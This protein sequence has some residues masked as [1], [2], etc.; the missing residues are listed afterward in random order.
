MAPNVAL[1]VAV[2]I[3]FLRGCERG[4]VR[5]GERGGARGDDGAHDGENDGAHDRAHEPRGDPHPLTFL[6]ARPRARACRSCGPRAPLRSRS[7]DPTFA[8]LL[9]PIV[10]VCLIFE[11]NPRSEVLNI[12]I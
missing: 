4:G 5:G 3:F 1:N 2:N 9:A 7:C 12:I 8:S 10:P 6:G 11:V